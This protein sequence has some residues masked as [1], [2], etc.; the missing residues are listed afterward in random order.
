MTTR[1]P[2]FL[3]TWDLRLDVSLYLAVAG[4]LFTVGWLRLRRRGGHRLAKGWR[5]ASY[6]AGL[7]V[8]GLALM[9]AIDVFGGLLFFVHMIQHLLLM[10][11]AP[12]LLLLAN[13]LPFMIWGLPE[14]G[15]VG[16]MLFSTGSWFRRALCQVTRPGVVWMAFVA[17]LWGWHDPQAYNA[18]L[19]IR[20]VHDLEHLTFFGTSILLWWHVIGAGPR[21]HGRFSPLARIGYLL[22]AAAANMIPGVV[23]ALADKPLYSYY[24]TVPRQWNLS[25]MQDQVLSGIIMWIPGTMMYLH[26]AVIVIVRTFYRFEPPG[27]ANQQPQWVGSEPLRLRTGN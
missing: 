24:L 26:A 13:P 5:L 7:A 17:V 3:T 16:R 2:V 21:I 27:V 1:L 15:Q 9:S 25:V 12:P 8:L 19:R 23:I 18:A 22:A 14:G 20:W 6:W 4:L 11:V 10:M